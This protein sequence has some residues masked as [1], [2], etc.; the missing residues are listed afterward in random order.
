MFAPDRQPVILVVDDEEM[1]LVSIKSFLMLETDYDVVTCDSPGGAV[2]VIQKRTID[3]VISDYLM[4]EMDGISFLMQVKNIQPGAI[5]VLLTGYADKENAIKAINDVGLYQYIEKPWQNADLA[6]V[7]KNG[8]EK[9]F[10]IERLQQKI[11]EV[12]S[13]QRSLQDIQD[14]IIKAFS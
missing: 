9:R 2:A 6:L 10:L 1:V 14:Q 4:P 8:L 13:A 5:R 7:I 11:M 3:L 12:Q